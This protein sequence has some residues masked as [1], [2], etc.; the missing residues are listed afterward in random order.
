MSEF[1]EIDLAIDDQRWQS[2]ADLQK[3]CE[4]LCVYVLEKAAYP[5]EQ[6]FSEIFIR[7]TNDVDIHQINKDFRNKDKPTNV[8]SF[9]GYGFV[10]GDYDVIEI[11]HVMLG[12]VILAYETIEKE[13][14]DAGIP[15]E[16]HVFHMITHG[17]L[18]LLGYD[19][20]DDQEAEE[21]EALEIK[22][23]AHFNVKSPY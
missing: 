21:M 20:E 10:P 13:A 14:K 6:T 9:P 3:K 18:H 12:D 15:F 22:I 23:L 17:V 8:L 11:P 5:I 7:F 16:H 19:H 4:R 2:I 1:L